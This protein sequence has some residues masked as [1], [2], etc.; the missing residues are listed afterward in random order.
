VTFFPRRIVA[1][2][3]VAIAPLLAA[4]TPAAA[5]TVS[6]RLTTS[7][8]VYER[9]D[10]AHASSDQ[11]H[12]YQGLLFSLKQSALTLHAYGQVDGD[13]SNSLAGDGKFRMFQLYLDWQPAGTAQI[14]IGRQAVF[15]G[16]GVGTVD[17]VGARVRPLPWLGVKAFAGGLVPANQRFAIADDLSSHHAWGGQIQLTPDPSLRG[18]LSYARKRQDRATYSTVRSDSL[19]NLFTQEIDGSD[20]AYELAS[21][22]VGWSLTPRTDLYG[23]A[24]LDVYSLE[25]SRA[26]V[27]ARSN[28]TPRI[29]LTGAYTF[30][31]P[32][33]PWNSI[34]AVFNTEDNHEIEGDVSYRVLPL[35]RVYAEAGGILYSGDQS[36]RSTLGVDMGYAGLSW[37]HRSGF[38]GD[39]EGLNASL[40]RPLEHGR[41]TPNLQ[42]SWASYRAEPG[43][44]NQSSLFSGAAGVLVEPV[45]GI[46]VDSE[47]QVLHNPHY[48]D[49]VR[50]LFRLQYWFF[51]KLGGTP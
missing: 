40:Y 8:Y 30:R 47:V 51:K 37:L 29:V 22:D 50:F 42:I 27:S 11:A 28:V 20:R 32:R 12:L 18:S 35:L 1:A 41:I 48:D 19:G 34:F 7:V 17:G 44:G 45:K 38:G 21:A 26:E 14:K 16:A 25:P 43:S 5:Q 46:S 23:R 33:M 2:T 49:D 36:F 39:L 3:L 24:D 31:S 15:A 6:G 9:S 13:V 4:I 10:S